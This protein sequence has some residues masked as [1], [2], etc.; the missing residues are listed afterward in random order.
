[1]KKLKIKYPKP[2]SG[3]R[4]AAETVQ[5]YDAMPP[6]FSL[7]RLQAGSYCLSVLE[8]DD[9]AAFAD[10]IFKRKN[11]TWAEI[12][13]VGRHGLG[14][15]K[16][17]KKIIRPS[18]PPFITEEIDSFLAFRFSGKKPMLGYRV[19]NVFYVLWFDHDYTVYDHG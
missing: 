14:F 4:V 13:Q 9:K 12:K 17:N 5:D 1:M 15:E 18:I 7:E 19:K 10:A 16:I 2:V 6:I 11:L 3:Q 8:K